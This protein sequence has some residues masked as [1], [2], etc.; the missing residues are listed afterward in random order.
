MGFPPRAVDGDLKSQIKSQIS[1]LTSR[2][3]TQFLKSC[4]GVLLFGGAPWSV[5]GLA[6]VIG[7]FLQK[8]I[9]IVTS[10]AVDNVV[11]GIIMV[12]AFLAFGGAIAFRL[13]KRL[14]PRGFI[15]AEVFLGVVGAF[16]FFLFYGVIIHSIID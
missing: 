14:L 12:A 7:D 9:H 11:I 5:I 10:D 13:R 1:N 6:T 4:G 3:L 15:V 8:H 16:V 2:T